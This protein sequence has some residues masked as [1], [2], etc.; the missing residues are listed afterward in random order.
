MSHTLYAFLYFSIDI[1]FVIGILFLFLYMPIYIQKKMDIFGRKFSRLDRILL[2]ASSII[3]LIC[4][5]KRLLP[6]AFNRFKAVP[7]K[8]IIEASF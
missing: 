5:Y 3:L 2:W 8:G 7:W 6:E 1:F 4:N